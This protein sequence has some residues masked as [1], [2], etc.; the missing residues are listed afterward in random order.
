MHDHVPESAEPALLEHLFHGIE[1]T[2]NFF[3]AAESVVAAEFCHVLRLGHAGQRKV[4]CT[5]TR[6]VSAVVG[7]SYQFVLAA[8]K[9]HQQVVQK[10]GRVGGLNELAKVEFSHAAAEKNPQVRT[11]K[12]FEAAPMTVKQAKAITVEG[13]GLQA[14]GILAGSFLYSLP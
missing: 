9:E 1:D 3:A 11:V 13:S 4:A 6:Q 12:H 2:G 10:L 14:S 7:G 8:F 5:N